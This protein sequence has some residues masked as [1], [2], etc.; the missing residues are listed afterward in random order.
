MADNKTQRTKA[1]VAAFLAKIPEPARRKETKHIVALIRKTTGDKPVMW[2]PSIIGF[3][4]WSYTASNGKEIAWFP[5]GLS[6]RK[7]ALT[8]YLMQGL[9][10]HAAL[11]KALGPHKIGGGCLY[12]PTPAEVNPRVLEKLIK[13]NGALIKASARRKR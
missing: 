5:V 1:S 13:A 11:L 9:K 6:P 10:P 12:L 4:D 7:S 8:L 2:G 3:G